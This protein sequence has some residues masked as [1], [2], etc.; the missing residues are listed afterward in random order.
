VRPAADGRPSA[1]D[2]DAPGTTSGARQ[3]LQVARLP[4]SS[5]ATANRAPQLPQPNS[6]RLPLSERESIGSHAAIRVLGVDV[7]RANSGR[8]A[9]TIKF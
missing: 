8:F 3:R 2:A 4:A 9:A 6:I 5:A 7:D 1:G